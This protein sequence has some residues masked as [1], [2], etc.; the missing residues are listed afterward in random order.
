MILSIGICYFFPV[1]NVLFTY[2]FNKFDSH[3]KNF[4][5]DVECWLYIELV[6][7]FL[8]ITSM[9]AFCFLAYFMKFL[10]E[11]RSDFDDYKYNGGE[12][13]DDVWSN[14]NSDDFLHYFKFEAFTLS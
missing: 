7:F 1:L 13:N 9:A 6:Y 5:N 4:S 11:W 14:K 3:D 2:K 12:G 10:S 8:W